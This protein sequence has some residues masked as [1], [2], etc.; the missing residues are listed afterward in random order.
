MAEFRQ[1]RD[2]N[3]TALHKVIPL[4]TPYNLSIEVSSLCNAGCVYCAHSREDH[5]QFEGNMPDELFEKILFDMKDFSHQIKK[6]SMFGFGEPLCNRKLPK[7]ILAVRKMGGV[8]E[9]DLTT[10]GILL[11]R[12]YTDQL[13]DAGID[14]I[15]ISL[16]GLDSEA[17]RKICNVKIDFDE[18]I[19]N[20][21]YLYEQRGST[22][23]RMKIADIAIRNV[24]DGEKRYED[25]FGPIADS[26]F[27]EHIMP[28]YSNVDYDGI[29]E[30]IKI[31]AKNGREKIEQ[32]QINKVCHRAFYRCR[33]RTDG[34][35]TAACC[36]STQDVTFGNVYNENLVDIWNGKRRKDFLIKLLK[37][38]R[39]QITECRY[40]MMPNDITTED[41]LLDGWAEE[42][43]SRITV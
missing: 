17:Y 2:E 14:T 7:M 10:N 16:Q 23:V 32:T 3:R 13:L 9:I 28:I 1:W 21:R 33:V 31:E 25:I 26:I 41:D 40:C 38:E 24:T 22:R 30:N 27:I 20:L 11:T 39:F 36:D 12:E 4:D 19:D 6:V 5:G 43:L 35:V 8:Q 29:D 34:R 42:I 18:F 15:R 37:G